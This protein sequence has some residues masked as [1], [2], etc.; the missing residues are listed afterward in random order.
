MKYKKDFALTLILVS[1]FLMLIN[2][3]YVA[4]SGQPIIFSSSS[5]GSIEELRNSTS[6][7]VRV[8][9]GFPNVA[10]GFFLLVWIFLAVINFFIALLLMI[11]PGKN[12][13]LKY[14]GL[15][16]SLLSLAYGGGFIVGLV[17]GFVGYLISF[18]P[19]LPFKETFVGKLF[20]AATLD[21]SFFKEILNER[22]ALNSGV[23]AL[24]FVNFF[25]GLGCALNSYNGRLL[26]DA[27]S[28]TTNVSMA[29][30]AF[31]VAF[32]GEIFVG[33]PIASGVFLNMGLA[34]VK[35]IIFSL[36]IYLF[37][38]MIF[39]S[40]VSFENVAK[41]VAFAY[42]PVCLQ[43]FLP[44]IFVWPWY[45]FNWPLIV[46]VVT[47]FWLFVVLVSGLRWVLETTFTRALGIS[48]LC[49]SIYW[50]VNSVFFVS[51]LNF[52][53]TGIM[54]VIQPVDMPLLIVSASALIAV[55]LGVFKRYVPV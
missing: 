29:K 24:V 51:L 6:L 32:L 38:L 19:N 55:L 23:R 45:S 31:R 11:R 30:L 26:S 27:L 1:A 3:F 2:A 50:F 52:P 8:T 20:R 7:W 10:E 35:W 21:S 42:A 4:V 5:I 54:L 16:L 25:S 39:G 14:V 37:C 41:I 9:F 46:G 28:A 47:N 48:I 53:V 15:V 17:L 36:I 13:I 43:V 40:S 44:L 18:Q 12:I 34:V 49:G 33:N 22:G